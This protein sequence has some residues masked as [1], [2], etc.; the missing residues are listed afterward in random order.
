M[1]FKDAPIDEIVKMYESGRTIEE[2]ACR[3]GVP[4]R[5]IHTWLIRVGVPR[6]SR[7]VPNG[8]KFSEERN[9]KLRESRKGYRMSE[10][11]KK[12][13]SES[14][15]SNYNGLN[16]YGHTKQ[17]KN[18]YV[19]AYCP[20]H[21]NAHKDGYVLL[22]TVVM[23]QHLGR[24]LERNEVAH[25]INHDRQDNRIENLMLMN[26]KEHMSMHAKEQHQL[27]RIQKCKASPSS[28]I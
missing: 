24:Y 8:H 14:R 5:T 2:V 28:A 27:R 6:R 25:H 26:R 11:Q 1:K 20:K 23:E 4:N 19:L 3:F 16:G 9:L 17:L 13:I 7:G 18:G 10:E 15:S 22:H 21:P 12:L